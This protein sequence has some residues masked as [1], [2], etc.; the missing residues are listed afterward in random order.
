[1]KSSSWGWITTLIV[2]GLAAALMIPFLTSGRQQ[3]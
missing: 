3:A 1:M 2:I